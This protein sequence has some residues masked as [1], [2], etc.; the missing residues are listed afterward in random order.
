LP[1]IAGVLASGQFEPPS[2]LVHAMT[3]WLDAPS[4]FSDPVG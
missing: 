2:L 1:T 4:G 3:V